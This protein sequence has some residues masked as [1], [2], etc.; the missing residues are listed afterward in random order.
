METRVS[1]TLVGLF[2]ISLSVAMLVGFF[3]LAAGNDSLDYDTYRVY[4]TDSVAGLSVNSAVRYKGVA[5]GTV[6]YIGLDSDNPEQVELRLNVERSTPIRTGTTATLV[7][8]GITGLANVELSGGAGTEA[9]VPSPDNPV[10]VIRSG[11]SLVTRLE[12]AFTN[13]SVILNQVLSDDNVDAFSNTLSSI[14]VITGRWADNVNKLDRNLENI[15]V[16]T[17]ALAD[18]ADELDNLVKNLDAT[19]ASTRQLAEN[20]QP[21]VLQISDSAASVQVLAED[22]RGTN[23]DLRRL[24]RTLSTQVSRWQDTTNPQLNNLLAEFSRLAASLQNFTRE[25]NR[26]PQLFLQGRSQG[27]PGPGE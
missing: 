1:Y 19:L 20:V 7:S 6:T 4:T 21:A 22:F 23:T 2:V 13:L 3:W 26:N 15:E 25:L 16:F 9:L 24:L 8:Q 27:R 18:N 12:D 14:N 11:P 17:Q 5:V 10:P